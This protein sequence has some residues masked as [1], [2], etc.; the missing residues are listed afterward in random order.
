MNKKLLFIFEGVDNSGKSTAIDAI[1]PELKKQHKI[2]FWNIDKIPENDKLVE[3]KRYYLAIYA[4]VKMSSSKIHVMDRSWISELVYS[5]VMR[6]YDATTDVFYNEL[7]RWL[8]ENFEI[9]IVF[10]NPI[11]NVLKN[12]FNLIGDS[13]IQKQNIQRLYDRYND[14]LLRAKITKCNVVEVDTCDFTTLGIA[15]KVVEDVINRYARD[16]DAKTA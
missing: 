2:C 12:R 16:N 14:F 8:L 5:S 6:G 9:Y 11:V 3:L 15:K 7:E 13:Y 1:F 10:C 4:A